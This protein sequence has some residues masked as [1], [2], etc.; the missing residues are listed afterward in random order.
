MPVFSSRSKRILGGCHPKIQRILNEAV[1]HID[2]KPLESVRLEKRHLRLVESEQSKVKWIDS[3]HSPKNPKN[4]DP[5]GT[6]RGVKA[7]DVI[8]YPFY[9]VDW[10]IH[11]KFYVMWGVLKWIGDAYGTPLTWGGDW[12]NNGVYSNDPKQN[13]FDLPHI[14]ARGW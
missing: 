11:D 2:L 14:Q 6:F 3:F 4:L 13:F 10:R 5:D 7:L 12:N 9:A 8:P 1:K